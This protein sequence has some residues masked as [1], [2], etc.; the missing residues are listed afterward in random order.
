MVLKGKEIAEAIYED[1]KKLPKPD[2]FLAGISV[3][4]NSTSSG[5]LKNKFSAANDLG[6]DFRLYNFGADIS[7]DKLR[8]EVGRIG[9]QSTCGGVILQLPLPGSINAQY[10]LNVITPGKDV[11]V[12]GERTLG[13]FYA[14]REK[15]LP[16]SVATMEEILKKFP[17]DLK[18]STVVVVGA[19]RLIGKPV[20]AWLSGKTK[21]IIILDKGSDYSL[22]KNADII[23]LGAGVPGLIKG[24]MFKN[25]AGVIDFG[26]A[27]NAAGKIS[28]DLDLN[29][30][31]DHLNFYTPTPGGTGPIL[32]AKIL[33]NFYKLNP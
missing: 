21:E 10:V 16:P 3:G 14:G 32:V 23:I 29:S 17:I 31:L 19:G 25:G 12:L 26:Y 2:K 5:F 4:D 11:D 22:L 18:E 33:E 28:G 30:K 7:G 24:E 1:L 8:E 20:A 9:N 13:V 6:V 27:K 15:V